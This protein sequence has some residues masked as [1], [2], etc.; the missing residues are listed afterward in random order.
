MDDS[1]KAKKAELKVEETRRILVESDDTTVVEKAIT[2][3]KK[4]AEMISN[5]PFDDGLYFTFEKS[6]PKHISF[7]CKTDNA[8]VEACDLRLFL[9]NKET[10]DYT[11]DVPPVMT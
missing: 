11:K 6:K 3:K 8:D 7:E 9:T 5:K 10:S 4:P 1:A 2:L